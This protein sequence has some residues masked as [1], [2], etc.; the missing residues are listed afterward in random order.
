MSLGNKKFCLGRPENYETNYNV[1]ISGTL[2]TSDSVT[3]AKSQ[4]V[5]T[6][7]F[8]ENFSIT[9][10]SGFTAT[11]GT[12]VY[13]STSNYF[14][15]YYFNKSCTITP[16]KDINVGIIVSG[17][18]GGGWGSDGTIGGSGGGGAATVYV[19]TTSNV[20]LLAGQ[21]Y[22][23]TVGSGGDGGGNSGESSVFSG[24][25][26]GSVLTIT[27][28]GGKGG[29]SGV[30]GV[31]GKNSV[32]SGIGSERYTVLNG[33][34]GGSGESGA[35]GD[36]IN[37]T[38]TFTTPFPIIYGGGGGGGGYNG[39]AV[40]QSASVGNSPPAAVTSTIAGGM[41]GGLAGNYVSVYSPPASGGMPNQNPG[42][43]IFTVG[44]GGGGGGG[45]GS[46]VLGTPFYGTTLTGLGAKGGIGGGVIIYCSFPIQNAN[47]TVNG[48]ISKTSGT[49]DIVHPLSTNKRLIHSF[50]EGPRCDLIY[51]GA[52]KLQNGRARVN[53]DTD[54][55]ND[56]ECC[57]ELGTFEAL[58][59]NPMYYLQN[60]SSFDRVKGDL[61]GN[62]LTIVC[63]NETSNDTVYWQVI[64]ERKD[65]YIKQ[66]NRTNN[67]GYLITEYDNTLHN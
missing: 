26:N 54:C 29:T 60:H 9:L 59:S 13:T 11:S 10:P 2:F 4:S 1:D 31:G 49:F 44:G 27:A 51:R 25:I 45:T 22:T 64:A 3:I 33:G 41:L 46:S 57:M 19:P 8:F 32:I 23:I 7:P 36:S 16:A 52:T 15:Y 12:N 35:K 17:G 65:E 5:I 56:I 38:E 21:T 67:N 37:S 24:N 18:G 30:G 43:Y 34:D 20:M 61:S 48:N 53:I 55:V 50:I 58:S 28:D 63:E 6:T 62:I 66:W 40:S 14:C 39:P 47:L 42:R